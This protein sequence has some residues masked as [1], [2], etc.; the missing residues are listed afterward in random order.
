VEP[1]TY[2]NL[3]EVKPFDVC[4]VPA[5]PHVQGAEMSRSRRRGVAVINVL[6]CS[7]ST[8]LTLRSLKSSISRAGPA[9]SSPH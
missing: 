1:Q 6:S 9:A 2:H 5:L 3:G 7:L 8:R 4:P